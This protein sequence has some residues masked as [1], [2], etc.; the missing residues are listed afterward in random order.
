MDF[1]NHILVQENNHFNVGREKVLSA[2]GRWPFIA[3]QKNTERNNLEMVHGRAFE[4]WKFA[5]S[6]LKDVSPTLDEREV[7]KFFSM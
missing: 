1:K 2:S 4:V 5:N 3:E 6:S 7:M